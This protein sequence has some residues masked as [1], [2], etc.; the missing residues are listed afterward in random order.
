M[1]TAK[2]TVAHNLADIVDALSTKCTD[3]T[4]SCSLGDIT[5]YATQYDLQHL[6][7]HLDTLYVLS[8]NCSIDLC[9]LSPTDNVKKADVVILG[10]HAIDHVKIKIM[11]SQIRNTYKV[12]V[13]L[14]NSSRKCNQRP[15]FRAEPV[16]LQQ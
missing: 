13:C 1:L 14:Q 10:N 11:L 4:A 15:L 8:F 16:W 2:A 5:R 12:L 6:R 3:S 7:A 9:T